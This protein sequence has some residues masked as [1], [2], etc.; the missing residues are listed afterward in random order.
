MSYRANKAFAVPLAVEGI[1]NGA[2]LK[3]TAALSSA[4]SLLHVTRAIS[5]SVS[6]SKQNEET[7][8]D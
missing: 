1:E 5:S 4:D 3:G 8:E 7:E 6:F 2:V